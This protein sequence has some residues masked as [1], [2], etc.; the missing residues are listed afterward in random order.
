M[1]AISKYKLT[2]DLIVKEFDQ[3]RV[4]IKRLKILK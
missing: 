3:R 2:N 4:L 1:K